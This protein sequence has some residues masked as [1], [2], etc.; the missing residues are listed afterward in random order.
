MPGQRQ[1]GATVEDAGVVLQFLPDRGG[2]GQLPVGPQRAA[3]FLDPFPQPWPGSDQRLVGQ[4][5]AILVGG[6]QP[7]VDQP[8]HHLGL[9][10]DGI[11]LGPRHPSPADAA[12][13][14]DV[15][16]PQQQAAYDPLVFVVQGGVRMFR[17]CGDCAVDPARRPVSGQRDRG[18]APPVPG[19]EQRM[20]GER[21]GA[22]PAADVGDDRRDQRSLDPGTDP[23]GRLH[24]RVAQLGR[25]HAADQ[26]VPVGRRGQQL[27]VID[28]PFIVV[29]PDGQDDPRPVGPVGPERYQG[30]DEP[31]PFG[32][33]HLGGEHRLELVDD[34]QQLGVAG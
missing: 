3:A 9:P 13:V 17:G 25:A 14:V 4:L 26:Y 10:R 21:E 34:Q 24:D 6:E 11:D 15:D 5:N 29:G 31:G 22:R 18:P 7:R 1:P 8:V 28:E 12:S 23:L 19:F 33:V 27:P 32:R 30:G 2:L 16:H 20:R